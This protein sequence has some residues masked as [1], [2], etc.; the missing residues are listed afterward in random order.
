MYWFLKNFVS[1]FALTLK[2]LFLSTLSKEMILNW[3]IVAFSW[4]WGRVLLVVPDHLFLPLCTASSEILTIFL[5]F[6][7]LTAL[8][9]LV[10]S[11]LTYLCSSTPNL[12]V[13]MRTMIVVIV[14]SLLSTLF[15]FS[16]CCFQYHIYI[17]IKLLPHWCL[18]GLWP[19]DSHLLRILVKR[20]CSHQVKALGSVSCHLTQLLY[21][22]ILDLCIV[23]LALAP[24]ISS[25]IDEFLI[26]PCSYI[27]F[28]IHAVHSS[29][30]IHCLTSLSL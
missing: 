17:L 28:R 19:H 25:L 1:L 14:P 18:A 22:Q 11:C 20:A 5:M 26:L 10:Y 2:K 9:L 27:A 29:W 13:T 8:W 21:Q 16:T 15:T 4:V 6:W 30:I 7:I 23:M 3:L 12:S 24:Y